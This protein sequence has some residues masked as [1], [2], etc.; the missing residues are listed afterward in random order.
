MLQKVTHNIPPVFD[1]N[2]RVLL[3][4]SMPSPK[5]REAA[6]YYAHPQNRFW[7]VLSTLLDFSLPVSIEQKKQMLLSRH[8]ALWDVIG[9]CEIIGASDS[10][11]KNA[12]PNDYSVIFDNADIKAVFT[13]GRTASLFYKKFTGKDSVFLPSTSPANNAVSF[14]SLLAAFSKILDYLN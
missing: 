4:G 11:I 5:S 6:F 2:C 10:T 14:E 8:I 13:L 12:T 7:K 1:K 3:L 9:S